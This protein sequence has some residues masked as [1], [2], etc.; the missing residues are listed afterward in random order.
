LTQ[1]GQSLPKNTLEE[2]CVRSQVMM[3]G[4]N[5]KETE[6]NI[7]TKRWLHT[8]DVGYIDDDGYRYPGNWVPIFT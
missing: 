1:H 5:K 3:Q 7:D 4:Y 8:D 2:L 6:H